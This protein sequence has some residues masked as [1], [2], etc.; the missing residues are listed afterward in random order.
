MIQIPREKSL[1]TFYPHL[2]LMRS[3]P[4]M[5]VTSKP[6]I[7]AAVANL[8]FIYQIAAT[9]LTDRFCAYIEHYGIHGYGGLRYLQ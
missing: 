5:V 8:H 4:I 1:N 2:I 3:C 6:D 7:I 9:H